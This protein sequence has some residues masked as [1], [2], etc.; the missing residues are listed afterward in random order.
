MFIL[1]QTLDIVLFRQKVRF[2]EKNNCILIYCFRIDRIGTEQR[3]NTMRFQT[4]EYLLFIIYFLC[5]LYFLY[6]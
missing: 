2:M 4:L 1:D 5:F 6:F 3:E